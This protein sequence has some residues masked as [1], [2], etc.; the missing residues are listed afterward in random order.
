M[1][2]RIPHI[3]VDQL[4][5]D[6]WSTTAAIAAIAAAVI[7]IATLLVAIRSLRLARS[8]TRLAKDALTAAQKELLLAESQLKS[9]EAASRQTQDALELSRAQLEY[10]QR[11]DVDRA[12]GLAPIVTA[13]MKL[14]AQSDHYVMHLSNSG[15]VASYLQITGYAAD[16]QFQRQFVQKLDP[17]ED[18]IVT[19]FFCVGPASYCQKIRIRAKDVLGNKYITEYR[20]LGASLAYPTFRAPWIGRDIVPRPER[21]SEEVSWP[22]EHF[23]R[24]P[25]QFDEPMESGYDIEAPA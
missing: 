17:G 15:A 16:G 11:A 13:E 20:S 23:E 19:Q 8:Q 3:I 1:I 5:R 24:T 4:P 6:Q 18:R 10:M 7:G 9:T 21:W 25:G 22:V 2:Q 14:R 12:K